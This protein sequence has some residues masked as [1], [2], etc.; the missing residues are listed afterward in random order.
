MT[1]R[2]DSQRATDL[3]VEHDIFTTITKD[4]PRRYL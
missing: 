4:F 3:P 1:G 2:F